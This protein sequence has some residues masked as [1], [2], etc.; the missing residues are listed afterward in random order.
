[1]NVC[2]F[3]STF[4][5][6]CISLVHVYYIVSIHSNIHRCISKSNIYIYVIFLLI[7][8]GTSFQL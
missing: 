5:D 7:L 1:M 8:I 2:M 6:M 3:I 4:L